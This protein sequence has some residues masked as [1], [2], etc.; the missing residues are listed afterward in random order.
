MTLIDAMDSGPVTLGTLVTSPKVQGTHSIQVLTQESF[1]FGGIGFVGQPVARSFSAVDISTAG[2]VF[3][4]V[5][6]EPPPNTGV[7]TNTV[8]T[9]TL[10]SAGGSVSDTGSFWTAQN[11]SSFHQV[12]FALDD[13]TETGTFDRTSV[14]GWTLDFSQGVFPT[15][16]LIGDGPPGF[17]QYYVDD[18]EW[19][20]PPVPAVPIDVVG[21]VKWI[22]ATPAPEVVV[23]WKFDPAVTTY[24]VYRDGTLV[25]TLDVSAYPDTVNKVQ[26]TDTS[27]SPLTS[28]VYSVSAA[29]LTQTSAGSEP[30]L[31]VV[32]QDPN[33]PGEPSA[34]I[35]Y[36]I[37][38]SFTDVYQVGP[39]PY[40]YTWEINPNDGGAIAWQK[41][42]FNAPVSGPNV[43]P[44]IQEGGLGTA[45]LS[46]SGIILTRSHYEVMEFWYSKRIL[47]LLKDDLNRE[48]LGVFSTWTPKR[49]RHS[50]NFWFHS[51]DA[52]FTVM[53]YINSAGLRLYGRVS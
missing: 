49:E 32:P 53:E 15:G 46:F 17:W 37:R 45:T 22:G 34:P 48:Y 42:F 47:I 51:Y 5:S 20:L 39:T 31:V 36:V 28:Y 21:V 52:Q 33:A 11:D 9:L 41:N 38:W 24:Y 4:W 13:M 25:D 6:A 40:T 18:L 35:G 44:I 29:T 23:S 16:S 43:M 1:G 50:S 27:V 8:I 10:T 12:A 3:I 2:S 26:Y 30:V 19:Q 7:G 14:T